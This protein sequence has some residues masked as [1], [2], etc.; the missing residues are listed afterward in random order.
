MEYNIRFWLYTHDSLSIQINQR[1][2]HI[3][4]AMNCY[5]CST[6]TSHYLPWSPFP[7]LA[8]KQQTS[9]RWWSQLHRVAPRVARLRK[10]CNLIPKCS[11]IPRKARCICA[12]NTSSL[13]FNKHQKKHVKYIS[14]LAPVSTFQAWSYIYESW[15]NDTTI[16]QLL[17]DLQEYLY[18][19][20]KSKDSQPYWQLS[21][22]ASG[23]GFPF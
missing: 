16:F 14:Q 15:I 1:N 6:A 20:L 13:Y 10:R 2:L 21:L 7:P 12:Q 22:R 11:K 18:I 8:P 5:N 17:R 23:D 9:K 19:N 4:V 3:L